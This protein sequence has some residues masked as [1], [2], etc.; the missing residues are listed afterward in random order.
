VT[1]QEIEDNVEICMRLLCVEKENKVCVE[2]TMLNG[3]K[4]T[5]DKLFENYKQVLNF[6]NDTMLGA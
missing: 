4:T 6:A 1:E 3:R 5:Y 2:F